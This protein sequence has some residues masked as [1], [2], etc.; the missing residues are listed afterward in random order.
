[1]KLVGTNAKNFRLENL[2]KRKIVLFCFADCKA[3][4]NISQKEFYT[5][6]LDGIKVA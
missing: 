3:L 5:A 1:M 2:A 4:K 6:F